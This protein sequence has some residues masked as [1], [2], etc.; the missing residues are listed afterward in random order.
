[1]PNHMQ[2]RSD[3]Y[4]IKELL[5]AIERIVGAIRRC[6]KRPRP[7][8]NVVVPFTRK[9]IPSRWRIC[10]EQSGSPCYC[11]PQL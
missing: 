5:V 3:P 1:M 2:A 7:T 8:T 11:S 9:V 10:G 4:K 6:H